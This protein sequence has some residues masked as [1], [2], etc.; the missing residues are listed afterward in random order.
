MLDPCALTHVKSGVLFTR[1][2]ICLRVSQQFGDVE[3][4]P[5]SSYTINDTV[6]VVFWT[7]NPRN[8]LMT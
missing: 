6:S 7:G 3:S 5:D 4:Q 2:A 8:N 1:A